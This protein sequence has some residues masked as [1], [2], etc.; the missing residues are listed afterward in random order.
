MQF[1]LTQESTLENPVVGDLM[2][3][4]GQLELF[5]DPTIP[6]DFRAAVAQD[7]RTRLNMFRGEWFLDL[8]EGVPYFENIIGVKD[9]DKNQIKSIFR[10]AILATDY[11]TSVTSL[12]LVI[13]GSTRSATLDF[14][15]TVSDGS[16]LESADFEPFIVS[17]PD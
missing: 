17:L 3:V 7:L 2:L 15:C 6:E 10:D 11:V 4:D 9:P 12:D 8:Q 1:R 5:G 16:T 14:V 13:D